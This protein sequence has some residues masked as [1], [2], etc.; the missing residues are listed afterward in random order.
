MA[1]VLGT[2]P[3]KVLLAAVLQMTEQI[4]IGFPVI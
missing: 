2:V 3:A 1:E 4:V